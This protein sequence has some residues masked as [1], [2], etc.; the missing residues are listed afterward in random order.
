M[1]NSTRITR[2]APDNVITVHSKPGLVN[3]IE[4]NVIIKLRPFMDPG[5]YFAEP[6][7]SSDSYIYVLDG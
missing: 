4:E 2:F 3:D 1:L 6:F 5:D 7:P